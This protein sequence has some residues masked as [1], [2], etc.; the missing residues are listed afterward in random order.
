MSAPEPS[1]VMADL[2]R[3]SRDGDDVVIHFGQAVD[4]AAPAGALQAAATS[5]IAMSEAG[6]ARLLDLLADLLR[7]PGPG[8]PRQP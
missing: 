1:Q 7:Q 2:C 6:G 4:A 8:G 3:V 5:R